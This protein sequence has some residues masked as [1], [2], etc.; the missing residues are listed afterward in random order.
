MNPLPNLSVESKDSASQNADMP[1]VALD[2]P[3]V[4]RAVEE[5][6]SSLETGPKLDRQE[7]LARY[8][9]IAAALAKCLDGLEFVHLVAPQLSEVC[10]GQQL[11]S[12]TDIQPEGPLGDF[13]LVREV[14]RGGMGVVYE[15]VQ[16]SLG[17]R[18]ALKVL[19]F[20]ATMD[21]KQLQRF[22]NEAQ[23]AAQ[24]H[25][26]NIV[27]VFG[28][29]CERGVH[30]YAMQFI[31]GQ[32]LASVIA[33]LRRQHAG[34]ANKAGR[35]AEAQPLSLT[36]ENDCEPL[37]PQSPASNFQSGAAATQ[38]IAALSTEHSL[39]SAAYFRAVA[40]LGVQAAEALEHA[41]DQGIMHRDVKPA[42]LLVDARAKLWITDFGLAHCQN[43]AGLTMSGDLVGTLR[44]MSPEQALAKR[45]I[46]DHRTDIYSLGA[47]LYELLTL[48]PAFTGSDRQELLRQIAF[49]ESK[50]PRR[51]A[52]S[53]PV[54]LETIILKALEKN[55]ADRYATAREMAED[56]E[57]FI[58]DEPIRARPPGLVRRFTKWV[59]RRRALAAAY[60][61]A[62]LVVILAGLS[63]GIAWLWHQAEVA[64]NQAEIARDDAN[65]ARAAAAQDQKRA[66]VASN[67]LRV[68]LAQRAWL[69]KDIVRARGL[70]ESCLPEHRQWE[71]HYVDHLC[72][73]E[74]LTLS[75]NAG[76]LGPAIFSSDGKLLARADNKT[77][78]VWDVTTGKETN[79]LAG[80]HNDVTCC[81]FSSDH[82]LLVCGSR[83]GQLDKLRWHYTSGEVTV[84]D[85]ATDKALCAFQKQAEVTSVAFSPDGRHV[86]SGLAN[87]AIEFWEV[88]TG[89]VSLTLGQHKNGV[90][91]LAFSPDGKLL[92]SASE[93]GTVKVWSLTTEEEVRAFPE[94][95]GGG[96]LVFSPDS[97]RL[98]CLAAE[99]KNVRVWDLASDDALLLRGHED[100]ITSLA[101]SPDGARVAAGGADK[102][103]RVWDLSEGR[104]STTL[105]YAGVFHMAY[106]PDGHCVA[107]ASGLGVRK[108][109]QVLKAATAEELFRVDALDAV[110]TGVAFSPDG[111]RLA[112]ASAD[113]MVKVWDLA[114]AQPVVALKEHT[115]PVLCVTYSPDGRR[116]ASGSVD[117]AVRVWNAANGQEPF[118]VAGHIGAVPRVAFSPDGRQL[119]SC[120]WDKTVKLWDLTSGQEIATLTGHTNK[121]WCVAYSPDGQRLASASYDGTIKLWDPATGKEVRTIAEHA[122][123]VHGV[124]F[125]SDGRRLASAS[126]D[127]TVRVWD[128]ATCRE[129][130][131]L[132]GHAG[133]AWTVAFSPDG[134]HLAS[135]GQGSQTRVWDLTT[136]GTIRTLQG[137]LHR[138]NAVAFSPDGQRVLSVAGDK[139]VRVW[140]LKS[141]T[142]P[143]RIVTGDAPFNTGSALSPD[144]KRL[145]LTFDSTTA[146]YDLASAAQIL[147]LN[148]D[149]IWSIAYSPDGRRL[150]TTSIAPDN[151]IKVWDSAKG[152][153]LLTFTGHTGQ[154]WC[155]AFSPDS[156][157]LASGSQDK[158]ACLWDA[159]GKCTA[160]LPGHTGRLTHVAFSPD[161]KLLATSSE[162]TTVKLW[163][164]ENGKEL[165][166]LGGHSAKVSG[167]AFSPNGQQL[168]SA[169]KDQTVK[170]WNTATGKVTYTLEGHYAEVE[171]V[172][173]SPDGRRLASGSN[174]GT[175]RLWDPQTGEEAL[176]LKASEPCWIYYVAFSPDGQRLIATSQNSVMIWDATPRPEQSAAALAQSQP[177]Q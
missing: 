13:R 108:T 56:L 129:T 154:V 27:P 23:A 115:G 14:G 80:L 15:A 68:H 84:W 107:I 8:P 169:S 16:I 49:E 148:A 116:L 88:T 140:D 95:V 133:Q 5:Y 38:P 97:L 30:Y 76:K 2:D 99:K 52:K 64:L 138:I 96:L 162:D 40:S 149:N 114:T 82:K 165:H 4:I 173:F 32:T 11:S 74:M 120:S 144:G 168:A 83:S 153:Q 18:V 45:V 111:Q 51:H 69:D 117:G 100:V 9:E 17:R 147:K 121:V 146:V 37:V 152:A 103:I 166:T 58:R 124:A 110:F 7:L 57:R 86:A 93:S 72:N 50:P 63:G 46:V 104:K 34:A 164:V 158:T 171:C 122:G 70:L 150:A 130:L 90:A 81:A 172:A 10:P 24:L 134:H 21:P 105:G 73:P 87:G 89:L 109:V 1:A 177:G 31:E 119:A 127:Q 71:W 53:I 132:R 131:K 176:T 128:V 151:A 170:L 123:G 28:V 79:T 106:S 155:V 19:P 91:G 55:P 174:D 175:V 65:T 67:L 92:A 54:E 143:R 98:A 113:K 85:L 112:T 141:P 167:V 6:L 62:L 160:I 39:K 22:K 26:T 145:A 61:L 137:H 94:R 161:G 3:R 101:F 20:A 142:G 43:Q 44:Y 156:K 33:D 102:T 48:E 12:A 66:V 41:H 75:L 157:R 125:S 36:G 42:N 60:G 29:G 139:T 136:T 59:R 47:T 35:A 25:H 159:A 163:D 78:K 77:I 135:S 118:T 126:L